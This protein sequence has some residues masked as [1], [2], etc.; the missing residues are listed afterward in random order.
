MTHLTKAK[1]T[2]IVAGL[3][4]AGGSKAYFQGRIDGAAEIDRE[5]FA[6]YVHFAQGMKRETHR[7]VKYAQADTVWAAVDHPAKRGR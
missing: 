7:P 1:L 5:A 3:L 2:L 4:M 6:S